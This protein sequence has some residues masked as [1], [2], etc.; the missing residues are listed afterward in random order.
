MMV[1]LCPSAR[2]ISGVARSANDPSE[3]SAEDASGSRA[4]SRRSQRG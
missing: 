3:P 1:V 4:R 2:T